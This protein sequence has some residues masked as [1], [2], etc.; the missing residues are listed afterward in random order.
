QAVLKV[1]PGT[2]VLVA[3]FTGTGFPIRASESEPRGIDVPLPLIPAVLPAD[4]SGLIPAAALVIILGIFAG[5]AFWYLVRMRGK[6]D[7]LNLL[8]QVA[9]ILRRPAAPG[10]ES[11]ARA[12]FPAGEPSGEVAAAV[13]DPL[14]SRYVRVLQEHG[15]SEA[16]FAVYRDFSRRIASDQQIKGYASLTPGELSRSCR[17]R[18]YC[19]AFSRFVSMYEMVRYGGQKSGTVRTEFE[20]VLQQ[21]EVQIGGEDHQE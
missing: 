14:F 8:A 16:A 4:Y 2:H 6:R 20:A 7:G 3:R 1:P 15:I 21:T 9:T 10:G 11:P 13:P 18:P 12:E 17:N 5:A 19:S